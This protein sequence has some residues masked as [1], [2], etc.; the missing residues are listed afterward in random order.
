[1]TLEFF[2]LD[3][4]NAAGMLGGGKFNIFCVLSYLN[5]NRE[6]DDPCC[7]HTHDAVNVTHHQKLFILYE[8]YEYVSISSSLVSVRF[9]LQVFLPLY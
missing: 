6:V 5:S 2:R 3:A 9:E 1:M 4:I 8:C 7:A